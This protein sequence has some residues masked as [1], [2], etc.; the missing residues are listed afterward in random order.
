MTQSQLRFRKLTN[1]QE[2]C[3]Q[4]VSPPAQKSHVHATQCSTLQTVM[5]FL[6]RRKPKNTP[7]IPTQPPLPL[8]E[9]SLRSNVDSP[10]LAGS[11]A[12][13]DTQTTVPPSNAKKTT[14]GEIKDPLTTI[15]PSS[16]T[17]PPRREPVQ[18][19]DPEE[20]GS[21]SSNTRSLS[22]VRADDRFKKA[23]TKLNKAM[24]TATARL[25]IPEDI[26]LQNLDH[27]DDV[28]ATSKKIVSAID[29]LIGSR[30]EMKASKGR[31][32]AVKDC[33]KNWFNASFPFISGT[34]KVVG[35]CN[36]IDTLLSSD[37]RK[38]FQVP[39]ECPS[40]L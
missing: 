40:P 12:T 34:L 22:R 29:Q 37:C 35:V 24:S 17:V 7:Q 6:K 14:T 18:E 28:E 23:A 33:A 13:R 5:H 25:K 32:Q 36:P 9:P 31:R 21:P 3:N 8:T 39:T 16:A 27:V 20:I 30:E 4:A 26:G 1:W 38:S 2:L 10:R 11:N 15:G 19:L